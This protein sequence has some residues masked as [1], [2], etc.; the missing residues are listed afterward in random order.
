[1]RSKRVVLVA[2]F[3][4]CCAPEQSVQSVDSLK[5]IWSSIS[6]FPIFKLSFWKNF[7]RSFGIPPSGYVYTC[8][9]YNE[10]QVNVWIGIQT[11]LS[12]MGGTLPRA[13]GWELYP[14][15]QGLQPGEHWTTT[16]KPYYFEM[17]I[18]TT[19]DDYTNHM[20]YIPHSDVLYQQDC[21]QLQAK[22]SK[23]HN[24]FRAYTGKDLVEGRFVHKPKVEYLGYSIM[25]GGTADSSALS[26]DDHLSS[27]TLYNSTNQNY[28]LGFSMQSNLT[29]STMT[30]NLCQ[31]VALVAQNSFAT[32][33]TFEGVSTLRPGTLGVFDAQTKQCVSILPIYD[34]GFKGMS[35]TAE[36][37]Q[38][39]DST[40]VQIGWQGLMS[41][42]YDLPHN[43]VRDITPI[44]SY[45]WYQSVQQAKSQSTID[46]PGS[47][48]IV[49]L[50]SQPEILA[51]A[52][53]GQA[54]M[55]TVMRPEIGQQKKLYFIYVD[56]PVQAQAE[57]FIQKFLS[58]TI[59]APLL[60][61][62]YE[63]I[64]SIMSQADV[65]LQPQATSAVSKT[66]TKT[67]SPALITAA[68]QGALSMNQGKI[69]DAQTGIVG[70]LLGSDS[71]LPFGVG[72]VPMYYSL[73]PSIA[74]SEKIPTSSVTNLFI[75]SNQTKA[76][77]GMPKAV[78]SHYAVA[79]ASV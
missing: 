8:S 40:G 62:Y 10:S 61:N 6:S 25:P 79:S 57:L 48:W 22:N 21:I 50:S 66:T 54:V 65:M 63:N 4:I 42:N 43:R 44:T 45:F 47:V 51:V 49:A 1:M 78:K 46:L 18:K 60:K 38:D 26:I 11:M 41:G 76:P 27:L 52:Q 33:Q 70:Y 7:G 53:P 24:Y 14:S 39:T 30:I 34:V 32:L 19:S 69:V 73:A 36:I 5:G 71:F 9:V 37:Y 77:Q 23:H 64:D 2:L 17:L 58:G 72:S 28:I 31:V 15:L 56:A 75:E 29:Q 3:I 74:T 13:N 68:V 59:G 35:Y 20:P 12:L 55:Y 16:D 67:V